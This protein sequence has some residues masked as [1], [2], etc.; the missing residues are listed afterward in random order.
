MKGIGFMEKTLIKQ[1]DGAQT[2]GSERLFLH[3]FFTAA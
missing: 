3:F 2:N 1:A